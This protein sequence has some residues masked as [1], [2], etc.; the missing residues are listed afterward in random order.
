[1]ENAIQDL[2]QEVFDAAWTLQL[3]RATAITV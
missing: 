3:Q 2:L 1:M